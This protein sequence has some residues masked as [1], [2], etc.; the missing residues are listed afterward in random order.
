VS[1]LAKARPRNNNRN[2][3]DKRK[4]IGAIVKIAVGIA[5]TI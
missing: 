1:N 2:N 3:N 5:I 4:A